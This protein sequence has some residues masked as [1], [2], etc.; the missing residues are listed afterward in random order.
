MQQNYLTV[1]VSSNQ[2]TSLYVFK[3]PRLEISSIHWLQYQELVV[4][5][6]FPDS[7]NQKLN[8]KFII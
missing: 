7:E 5:N 3:I 1:T 8:I 6:I 4:C 2:N